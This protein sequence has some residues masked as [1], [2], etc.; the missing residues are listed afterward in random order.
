MYRVTVI[1]ADNKGRRIGLRVEDG[2][3]CEWRPGGT[4]KADT[5]AERADAERVARR[6]RGLGWTDVIV[7]EGV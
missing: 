7:S 1:S 5:W 6:L 2:I 4:E 3:P